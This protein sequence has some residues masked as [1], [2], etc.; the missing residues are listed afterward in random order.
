M[1]TGKI[2]EYVLA[3][4]LKALLKVESEGVCNG[5]VAVLGEVAAEPTEYWRVM[6]LD[7]L[8]QGRLLD[9]PSTKVKIRWR[10]TKF[11][12]LKGVL[13]R[14]SLDSLLHQSITNMR[15][16]KPWVKYISEYAELSNRG[17]NFTCSSRV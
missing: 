7:L 13:Y 12:V 4:L 8:K 1:V 5:E 17:Q 3:I 2:L 9:N 16:T 15:L 11:V 14:R 10:L 6:F